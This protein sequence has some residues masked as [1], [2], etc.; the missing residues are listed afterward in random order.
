MRYV[1]TEKISLAA[2]CKKEFYYD[3]T[4]SHSCYQ[5]ILFSV[6]QPFIC[7]ANIDVFIFLTKEE[8]LKALHF[9]PDFKHHH[10]DGLVKFFIKN[11]IYYTSCLTAERFEFDNQPDFWHKK[12]ELEEKHLKQ[13]M[14]YNFLIKKY[15]S[16]S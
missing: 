13:Y 1:L 8:L 4:T 9:I 12:I 16:L 2:L 5:N 7:E 6:K 14:R 15:I 10:L 11:K 3:S